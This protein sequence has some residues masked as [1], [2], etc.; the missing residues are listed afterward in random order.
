MFRRFA[1]WL[2]TIA[3]VLASTGCGEAWHASTQPVTGAVTVNGKPPV[4]AVVQLEA[5]GE[6]VDV[7]QSRP[8]GIVQEDGTFTLKTYEPGDG[9]PIGDYKF[10]IHWPV[11]YREPS[12]FD[13][14]DHK[15]D[16]P[17]TSQITISVVSGQ[18]QLAPIAIENA[19]VTNAPP[20]R[21]TGAADPYAAE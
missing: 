5:I 21:T 4:G 16:Q 20:A 3:F 15:Y 12:S 18:S 7:R 11:D 17:E 8:L 19:K 6:P 10:L 2:L 9:A 14:L 1:P 13:R